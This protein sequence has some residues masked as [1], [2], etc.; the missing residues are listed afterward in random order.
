VIALLLEHQDQREVLPEP[1]KRLHKGDQVLLCG[2]EE[3]R[4][5][6]DW[7]LQDLHTLSYVVK[8]EEPPEGWLWRWAARRRRIR[9]AGGDH[10][11]AQ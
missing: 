6:L 4:D 1:S 11:G 8:G 5:I 2:R 10:R 9:V 7:T 3:A